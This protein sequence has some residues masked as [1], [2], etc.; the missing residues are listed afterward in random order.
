MSPL[1]LPQTR[2]T[3][4]RD[5]TDAGT[6]WRQPQ[7]MALLSGLQGV[8]HVIADAAYDADALRTVIADNLGASAQIKANPSRAIAPPIDWRLYEERHPVECFFNK[9]KRFRRIALRCEK[10]LPAFMGFV[11]LAC[12]LIWL[13]Y[14][15]TPPEFDF[16]HF[17]GGESHWSAGRFRERWNRHGEDRWAQR[18]AGMTGWRSGWLRSGSCSHGRPGSECWYCDGC[19]PDDASPDG[20][21]RVAGHGTRGGCGLF[22]LSRRSQ[23]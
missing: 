19:D 15:Q 18:S 7:A 12:A 23:P 10:T 5:Q 14:V 8:G 3:N 16:P 17:Q 20:G 4:R 1:A 2:T 6:A 21:S 11:H 22:A 13:R 9:L